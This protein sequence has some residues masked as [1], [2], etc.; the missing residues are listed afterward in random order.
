MLY[1]SSF[2]DVPNQQQQQQHLQQNHWTNNIHKSGNLANG[3]GSD[4]I[5]V[6]LSSGINTDE[7]GSTIVAI[8]TS[9]NQKTSER[10]RQDEGNF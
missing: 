4:Q 9:Y 10:M 8:P 7:N 6:T 3:N 2:N 1:N 5:S